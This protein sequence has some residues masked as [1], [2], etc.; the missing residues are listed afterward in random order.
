[1]EPALHFQWL[2]AGMA[3]SAIR[4]GGSW[5]DVS[6]L[7]VGYLLYQVRDEFRSAGMPV[8]LQDIVFGFLA[9]LAIILGKT[10]DIASK[11]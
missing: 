2:L 3:Q 5:N 8:V 4:G 9:R 11:D 10:K 1:V 7:E 6:P